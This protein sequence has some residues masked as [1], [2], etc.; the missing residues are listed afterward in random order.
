MAQMPM[1]SVLLAARWMTL[2]VVVVVSM[3][4]SGCAST[5]D[6]LQAAAG[7]GDA[8][9]VARLLEADADPS[10]ALDNAARAG[11]TEIVQMLLDAGADPSYALDDAARAGHTEIVRILLDAGARPSDALDDAA[12]AGHVEIVRVLLGAGAAPA[13][14]L[15]AAAGTGHTEIV[16]ILLDTG[17]DPSV[18]LSAAAGTG[19]SAIVRILLGAGADPSVGLSA[20]AGTRHT[21][22]VR[23]LLGAGADP[24]VGLSAAARSGRSEIVAALLGAG[25]DPNATRWIYR[26]RLS[27]TPLHGAALRGHLEAAELLIE[28]GADKEARARYKAA[29]FGESLVAIFLSSFTPFMSPDELLNVELAD[30]DGWTPLQ[31]ASAAGHT[32]IVSL[33]TEASDV[34]AVS[35]AARETTGKPVPLSGDY[36]G[37]LWVALDS[38][39]IVT[40]R[41]KSYRVG[42]GTVEQPQFSCIF[43]FYGFPAGEGGEYVIASWD[44][45]VWRPD[46]ALKEGINTTGT[47]SIMDDS[48]VIRFVS[49]P[50][51]GCWN[52]APFT[53]GVRYRLRERRAWSQVRVVAR[54]ARLFA[55]PGGVAHPEAVLER[56]AL[57]LVLE[58]RDGWLLAEVKR[59]G[60]APEEKADRPASRF[61]GWLRESALFSISPPGALDRS[62]L[63]RLSEPVG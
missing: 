24:S 39:G 34:V 51:G 55:S 23:M 22:I 61:R 35:T 17:A 42:L 40:G 6:K 38:S 1:Y 2:P 3:A 59:V 29:G 60:P 15:S 28:A 44:P 8:V 19:H 54:D 33:L 49:D 18:G 4:L 52:V 11:H 43:S 47:L 58:E 41:H 27:L 56:G 10:D 36:G 31:F 12:R 7:K 57:A 48:V 63:I 32:E 26:R 50:S 46:V 37:G 13:R 5:S 53:Q 30:M 16:L 45:P 20:A 14:G 21:D 62:E 9:R 25:G